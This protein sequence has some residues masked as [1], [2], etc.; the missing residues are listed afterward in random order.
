MNLMVC[1]INHSK[2]TVD[3]VELVQAQAAK[4]VCWERARPHGRHE[5]AQQR[6][7]HDAAGVSNVTAVSDVCAVSSVWAVRDACAVSDVS[8]VSN[9]RAISVR[10]SRTI[11]CARSR[12]LR[13]MNIAGCHGRSLE[14]YEPIAVYL[15]VFAASRCRFGDSNEVKAWSFMTW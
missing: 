8:A 3:L 15:I 10:A 7:V 11:R 2:R 1:S 6:R 4:L 14:A 9:V 12:V 13:L 5:R